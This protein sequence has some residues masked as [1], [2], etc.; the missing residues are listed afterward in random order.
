MPSRCSYLSLL[1]LK[2]AVSVE[3]RRN[4]SRIGSDD[5]L[6]ER[7]NASGGSEVARGQPLR[8]GALLFL[9]RGDILMTR[10]AGHAVPSGSM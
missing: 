1:S 4:E 7:G 6:V 3:Q 5:C 9:A 10:Q 8:A 2:R